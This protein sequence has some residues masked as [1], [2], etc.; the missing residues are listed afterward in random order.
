MARHFQGRID[1]MSEENGN[2]GREYFSVTVESDGTRTLRCVCEMDLVSLIRDVTYTVDKDFRARDCFVRVTNDHKF[3]GTGWF[4]FHDDHVEGEAFTA[5]EGRVSQRL[6]TDGRVRLFGT[7]PIAVDIWKCIHV[8]AANPGQVQLLDNCVNSSAVLNGASGPLLGRKSYE[9][10][11][12]GKEKVTVPAGTFDC[13][14]FDWRTG[15]GRT[16]QL[17]TTPGDWLP[18]KTVVPEGKRWYELAAFSEV[19][20]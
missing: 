14:Y 5:A 9:M 11:Y 4:L 2:V 13:E 20:K 15:T 8:K 12:R 1:Y 17:Y 3:V 16:L 19:R 10:V 18:I 7:H 6:E